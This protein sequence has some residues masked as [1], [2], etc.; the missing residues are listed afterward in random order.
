M[1][2][3]TLKYMCPEVLSGNEKGNSPGVDVW[4]MGCI[5]YH[6]VVGRL[7]FNG[8]TPSEVVESILTADVI[9]P[10]ELGL[11]DDCTSLIKRYDCFNVE[12]WRGIRSNESES[13][14]FRTIRG[15]PRINCS[16]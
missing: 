3:G 14:R 1:R 16:G 12:C 8:A 11:S 4:A 7:P 13:L 6:L 15:S 9:I 5:L 10:P 2:S